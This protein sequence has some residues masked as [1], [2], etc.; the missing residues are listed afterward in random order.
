MAIVVLLP[1]SWSH[2]LLHDVTMT[3]LINNYRSAISALHC[4]TEGFKV[5]EH[6]QVRA[7]LK[8]ISRERP[9]LPKYSF[10][11][12][13]DQVF[14]YIRGNLS[15][16]NNLTPMQLSQKVIS[17]LGLT[18]FSRGSEC[19]SFTISNI[20]RSN[21]SCEFYPTNIVKHSKEGKTNH[22]VIVSSFPQDKTI[23]PVTAT[24]SFI[25]YHD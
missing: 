21:E 18:T 13:V 5:G 7:L 24:D 6:P 10:T 9:P 20:C 25:Y 23:C 14:N 3:V 12:D 17:L 2:D 22:P 15:D 19:H 1:T 16:Y 11:W 4:P 8:G